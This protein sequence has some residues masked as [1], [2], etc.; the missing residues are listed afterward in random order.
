MGRPETAYFRASIEPNPILTNDDMPA[1][2]IQ[3]TRDG[4]TAD[5]AVSLGFNCYSWKTRFAGEAGEPTPRELLWAEDAMPDGDPRPSRSGIPL[6][7]PF[8][9]RIGG[10]ALEW[11]GKR[12]ELEEN[13]GGG[14][15]IH[16][17]ALRAAWRITEQADDRVTATFTPKID[18]PEDA[19]RWPGE[20]QI[21]ATYTLEAHRLVLDFRVENTGT[22]A[23]PYGFGTHAYFRLPLAEG[24]DAEATVVRA[25]VDGVWESEEMIPTGN[26][27]P[28]DDDSLPEG[29]PLAGREFDTVFRLAGGGNI[30]EVTDPKTGRTVR[31]TFDDSMATCVIYTPGHREAI[32]L[33]PYTCVPDPFALEGKGAPSGLRVLDPGAFYETR[34]VLEAT[35]VAPSTTA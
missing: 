30:T 10:A 4:A 29:G 18:A 15:A 7:A 14:N 11:D 27:T 22:V 35:T 23:V 21:T 32:C 24:G 13:G 25:P 28:L 1:K 5:I 6:L 2:T 3:L 34:V 31:Q 9:G 8:P 12:Y 33:E 20:Y 19:D 17:F 26:V 16:G